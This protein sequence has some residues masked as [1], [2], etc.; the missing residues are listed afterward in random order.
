MF[1]LADERTTVL[2]GSVPLRCIINRFFET[3][4]QVPDEGFDKHAG[5]IGG[6]HD[7][8]LSSP[9]QLFPFC[10]GLVEHPILLQG[11]KIGDGS[12]IRLRD[13]LRG[14]AVVRLPDFRE[15]QRF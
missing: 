10:V 3:G 6:E 2:A 12:G 1:T 11:T 9:R 15:Q 14:R 7:Y 5:G 4:R 13:V 8:L